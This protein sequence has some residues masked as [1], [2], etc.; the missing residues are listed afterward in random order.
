MQDETHESYIDDSAD[1]PNSSDDTIDEPDDILNEESNPVKL[2]TIDDV[3]IVVARYNENL[4]WMREY[5]FNIFNYTVYNKGIND[6]FEKCNVKRIINIPNVGRCDHTYL[7]HIIQN[8][9][10]LAEITVFLAGSTNLPDKLKR[11]T[12]ILERIIKNG[13]NHAVFVG[14]FNKSILNKFKD[15]S[16]THHR[17][18]DDAN[19]NLNKETELQ[20]CLLRPYGKWYLH[21][22]GNTNVNIYTYNSIFSMDKKDII[23]HDINRYKKLI[24]GLSSHHNPEVGHYIER[25]WGAVF[26]PFTHTKIVLI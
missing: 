18:Y 12:T 5:P 7:Y 14:H 8:Y 26:H 13:F 3:E 23:K 22:F 24:F 25:S 20:P 17:C 9:N 4:E 21:H 2:R 19:Y 16:L 10:N 11:A 1:I 15:F 6:N